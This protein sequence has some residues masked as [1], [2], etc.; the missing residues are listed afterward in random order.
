M[1]SWERS[2]YIPWSR[3]QQAQTGDP[4][5]EDVDLDTQKERVF[6]QLAREAAREEDDARRKKKGLVDGDGDVDASAESSGSAGDGDGD[7]GGPPA[8]N[9]VLGFKSSVPYRFEDLLRNVAFGGTIGSITGSVFGFMD[10]MKSAGDSS[11][12]KKASNAA[13]G[14]Y[15]LQGT[16][17]SGMIFGGFFGGFHAG[18]YGVRVLCD[19]GDYAEMAI[20]GA[21]GIGAMAARPQTR[22]S[23]PYAAMLIAM[24]AFNTYMRE[25][26]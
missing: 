26:T 15:L 23:V 11:V 19:P 8:H 17:R 7:D 20:A 13:K 21:L 12:L 14:R 9:T 16:A 25:Y 3:A 18:K 10:G 2:R 22:P 5:Q 4:T 24:D 1:S 6:R